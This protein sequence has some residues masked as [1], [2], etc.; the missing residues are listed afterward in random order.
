MSALVPAWALRP[1]CLLIV[2]VLAKGL[3]TGLAAR[4]GLGVA[5]A[6][7]LSVLWALPAL[8]EPDVRAALWLGGAGLVWAGVRRRLLSGVRRRLGTF[9]TRFAYVALVL[10]TGANI[11]VA[12]VLG[13]PLTYPILHAAGGALS[14]SL[15]VY[16]T[17]A[18]VGSVAL[19]VACAGVLP[20]LLRRLR[21]ALWLCVPLALILLLGPAARRHVD[22][23]GLHR[24][25]LLTL[26]STTW[27]QRAPGAAA[28]ARSEGPD[29][30][31]TVRNNE[32]TYLTE[33]SSRDFSTLSAITDSVHDFPAAASL[34]GAARGRNVVW[35][36][37]ESTAAQYLRPFGGAR[38]PMPN[39][40]RLA[41]EGVR[42]QATYAA[43]PESIKGLFAT[44]CATYPAAHTP[45]ER[46]TQ[47]RHPCTS[48]AA[49]MQRAGYRTAMLH[50]GW[51]AYLGMDGVVQDRGFDVLTDAGGIGG[52]YATSFGVDE[53]AT[54]RRVLEFVDAAADAEGSARKPFFVMYLPIAGHHP[55][56]APGPDERPQPFG[57][58]TD[59][60]NYM[61]DLYLGDQALGALRDGLR[62][63]GL[64]EET[65]WIVSGDHGEAFAQHPG[66]F[67][68]T[69]FL[70]EENIH[71]PLV[72]AAPG[73]GPGPGSGAFAAL[74]AAGT[75]DSP[76]VASVLDIAP[77]ILELCGLAPPRDWQGRSLL[78]GKSG[79]ARFQIDHALWQ[80]GLRH[81]P[82]KFIHELESGRSRLFDLRS[83]PGEQHDCA[84]DH[85]ARVSRY[86]EHLRAFL[87]RQRARIA[88]AR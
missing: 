25:A 29:P 64:D 22:T 48:V 83:D 85:P 66:N 5:G 26:L 61:N 12:R 86:R 50:A 81:G 59:L 10:Y 13:T 39:L 73:P 2:F 30:V 46:Y 38:D 36:I 1:A 71:V 47:A 37:L 41:A 49:A 14:D 78:D 74:R 58:A 11:P 44:L 55:Y 69:L 62:Q 23:R 18:N 54:V 76:Q 9:L 72:V 4:D 52:R 24:N 27:A 67:A 68:H 6:S 87:P 17:P 88:G 63:R 40:T 57:T 79:V 51:F 35:V 60:D 33:D 8:L 53:P 80:V 34:R 7:P 45:A 19:V 3:V 43:Y 56:R 84:A 15:R 65:L 32:Q 82:F 21:V 42:F 16:V 31:N 20:R 77:T 70:Y 28:R 75:Q